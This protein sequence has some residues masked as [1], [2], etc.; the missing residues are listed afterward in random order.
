MSVENQFPMQEML[1]V[2]KSFLL[3]V[4]TR[5]QIDIGGIDIKLES[6][7]VGLLPDDAIIIKH[8]STG[9]LGSITHKI[10]K[11]NKVTVRY[12]H[13]GSVFAFQSELLGSTNDPFKLLF[14]A[15]PSLI[16][17][18]RLRKNSR[19][20]CYLPAEMFLQKR[21]DKEIIP[22]VGYS[23]IV[24]DLSIQGCC[25]GMIKSS[26]NQTLPHIRIEGSITVQIQLPGIETKIELT[27]LVRRSVRDAN[28]MSIGIQFNEIDEDIKNRIADHILA[29]EQFSF[30]E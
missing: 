10:F 20:Q 1:N 26:N 18:H 30:I 21:N 7:V 23:G 25:F 6:Y 5:L 22:D 12:I 17:R 3:P 19:V 2:G 16:A 11:G 27:G 13:G 8:P 14:I 28:K 9:S 29:I 4:G 15:Y 24:S